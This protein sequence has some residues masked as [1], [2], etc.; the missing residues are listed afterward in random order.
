MD[1]AIIA[2]EPK[3]SP[4]ECKAFKRGVGFVM[5]EIFEK[6]VQPI[7]KQHPS[8]KPPGMDA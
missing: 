2:I 7:C 5:Y 1:A 3:I 8:L 4:E 6:I